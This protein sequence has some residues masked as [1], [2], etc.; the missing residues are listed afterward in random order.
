MITFVTRHDNESVCIRTIVNQLIEQGI[1]FRGWEEQ[2]LPRES[3]PDFEAYP[4]LIAAEEILRDADEGMRRRLEAYASRNYVY[5]IGRDAADPALPLRAAEDF[6]AVE[7]N[8]FQAAS[9]LKRE[10]FPALPDKVII[11]GFFRRAEEYF[12][13]PI[14]L[15]H[16][17]CLSWSR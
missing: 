2:E 5:I 16:R 10:E 9:G 15:A 17:G 1:R 14:F 4:A 7:L 3:P 8:V 6:F 13:M 12:A 11:G